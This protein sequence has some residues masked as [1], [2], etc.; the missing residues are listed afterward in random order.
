MRVEGSEIITATC[1]T[2][3][4]DTEMV[5]IWDYPETILHAF[6]WDVEQEDLSV[7]AGDDLAC[8]DPADNE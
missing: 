6:T 2:K 1:F 8:L 4:G 5:G 3:D 7:I